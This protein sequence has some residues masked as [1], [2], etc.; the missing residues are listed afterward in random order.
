[1]SLKVLPERFHCGGDDDGGDDGGGG[2]DG[3][4]DHSRG[5]SICVTPS[6]WKLDAK[7]TAVP[8]KAYTDVRGSIALS[9]EFVLRVLPW[10]G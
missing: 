3:A 7:T 1:M 4:S 10:L 8:R 6:S 2:H 5:C 9:S